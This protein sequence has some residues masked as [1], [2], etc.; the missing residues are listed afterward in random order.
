MFP[1]DPLAA[2]IEDGGGAAADD[3]RQR[4][5]DSLHALRVAA[6]SAAADEVRQLDTGLKPTVPRIMGY[7]DV[8]RLG[9]LA[10]S[11]IEDAS[12]GSGA[13]LPSYSGVGPSTPVTCLD[14]DD[15]ARCK[16]LVARCIRA[17]GHN[18]N[19]LSSVSTNDV[20]A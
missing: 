12:E 20:V 3:A 18:I 4:E 10:L 8:L 16:H 6:R 13:L 5:A 15:A 19:T 7:G 14:D 17:A 2:A 11:A 1:R 9:S